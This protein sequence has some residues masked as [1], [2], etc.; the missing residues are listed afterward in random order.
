MQTSR[1]IFRPLIV[2]GLFL[3]TLLGSSANWADGGGGPSSG[4]GGGCRLQLD[5][6]LV[7][8]TAYQ[9][10]LTG[11]SPYC[12]EIP[13]TGNI[14][15]VFDLEDKALRDIPVEFEITREKDGSR[16]MHQPPGKILNGVFNRTLNITE[17]GDYIAK[18][19]LVENGKKHEAHLKFHVAEEHGIPLNTALVI[20]IVLMVAGYF[21][22]QSNP[23]FQ[24]SVKKLM[25]KLS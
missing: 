14:S 15:V 24:A 19:S 3:L 10:Q 13:E 6:H 7:S 25:G 23:A 20:G 18:V 11:N 2:S 16:I 4:P 22:Y 5:T 1:S 9:P 8:F 21:L 17:M 12:T